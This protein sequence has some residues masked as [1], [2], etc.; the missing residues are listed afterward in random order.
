MVTETPEIYQKHV[1]PYMQRMRDEGRLN[2]VFNIIDGRAERDSVLLRDPG[3]G[4]GDEE[5]FLLTPDLNWDKKTLTGLHLLALV[6]RRDIWSLRDLK[7]SHVEWLKHMREKVLEA[8]VKLYTDIDKDML[9]LYVHCALLRSPFAEPEAEIFQ[10]N[11]HIITS[12]SMWC[13][14]WP[15]PPARSLLVKPSV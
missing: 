13:T 4:Q 7:K 11:P 2:W 3:R 14:S 10:T 5:R 15:R 9:K 8:T 6:E 12:T 1:Q